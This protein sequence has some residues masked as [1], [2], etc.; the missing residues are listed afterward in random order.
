MRMLQRLMHD[1]PLDKP[2]KAF[3]DTKFLASDFKH[4]Q[5]FS[6][7]V[8]VVLKCINAVTTMLFSHLPQRALS[9]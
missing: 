9:R 8:A 6:F 2:G 4:Q 5:G 3:F 1:C 7:F